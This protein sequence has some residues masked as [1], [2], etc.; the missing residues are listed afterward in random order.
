M[1]LKLNIIE[2]VLNPMTGRFFHQDCVY[3]NFFSASCSVL[4][5][6]MLSVVSNNVP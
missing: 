3:Y 1:N 6:F 2:L 4:C 5:L